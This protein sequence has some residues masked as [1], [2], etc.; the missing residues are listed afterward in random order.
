MLQNGRCSEHGEVDGEFDLRIKAVLD[1]G[2]TTQDVLFNKDATEELTD[3]TL[4]EAKQM[5]KDALDTSVVADDIGEDILGRYYRVGGPEM[6]RYLLA[7]EFEQVGQV[8]DPDTIL[9]RARVI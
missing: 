2:D 4:A 6:G 9:S 3:L 5:A 1:D 7:N 8:D